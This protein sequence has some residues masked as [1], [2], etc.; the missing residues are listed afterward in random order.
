MMNWTQTPK[1]KKNQ[2]IKD[3]KMKKAKHTQKI[4]KKQKL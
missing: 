2:Y 4:R 3:K 1:E